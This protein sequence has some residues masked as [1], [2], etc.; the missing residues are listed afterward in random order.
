[1]H[2]LSRPLTVAT[3]FL[4]VATF[5]CGKPAMR[6]GF[7]EAHGTVTLDGQP[8]AGAHVTF[9]N[10]KGTSFAVAD[11]AGNYVAEYSRTLKGAPI[12]KNRIL[13]STKVATPGDDQSTMTLNPKTGE[14]EKTELVPAK[15]RKDAPI[16]IDVTADGAP[17]N[18][19]LTSK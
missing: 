8:L 9:E 2:K 14:Y 6:P 1:M 11:S 7:A 4:T 13:I 16:E 3:L 19:E 17:Y 15:Y 10:E 5:G 12:G 18:F